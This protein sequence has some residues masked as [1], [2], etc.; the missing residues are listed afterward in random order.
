MTAPHPPREPAARQPDAGAP[1]PH[2]GDAPAAA[3]PTCGAPLRPDQ[4]WCLQCGEAVTTHVAGAPGWRTPVAIVGVVLAIAAAALVVAFLEL[5]GD[6]EREVARVPDATA[7]AQP[8]QQATEPVATATPDVAGP[9]ATAPPDAEKPDAMQPG[10]TTDP[11]ATSPPRPNEP[12]TAPPA[13]SGEIQDWPA[14]RTAYTVV[15]ASETSRSA[16]ERKARDFQSGG[17]SI[18]ILDSDDFSSLNPGYFVVFS[19]Q[20]DDL[21]A[22]RDAAAGLRS[23]EPD[24]YAR[25]VEPE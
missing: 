18:G 2:P 11:D 7:T 10:E 20:Y 4:D 19:G 21:E 13:T 17:H 25:R 1:A 9:G 15:L 16:A 24:A 22:A 5:S 3:C 12:T 8:G 14:G 6:A 23:V